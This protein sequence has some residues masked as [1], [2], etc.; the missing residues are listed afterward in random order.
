MLGSKSGRS[1]PARTWGPSALLLALPALLAV[2]LAGCGSSSSSS[3]S[4]GAAAGSSA[5]ASASTT[6]TQ[7]AA[8]TTPSASQSVKF[9]PLVPIVPGSGAGVKIGYIALDNSV[10]YI[11]TVTEGMQ[12]AAKKAGAQLFVCDAK[13]SASVAEQ[14]ARNFSVEGA[15][16]ILNFNSQAAASPQVCAAGPKVPT[17]AID[18]PQPPCQISFLGVSNVGA[19]FVDG[20]GGALAYKKKADCKYDALVIVGQSGVGQPLTE[21]QQGMIQGWTSVC[22][23]IHDMRVV[24]TQN[25][26]AQ[27][28]ET[29]TINALTAL[30]SPKKV[31]IFSLI[32]IQTDGDLAAVK[33]SGRSNDVSVLGF[34]AATSQLCA[35]MK[36]PD[37]LGD[38]LLFPEHY[39]P[40]GIPAMIKAIKHETIPTTLYIPTKFG[41]RQTIP[42]YYPQLASCASS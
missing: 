35:F 4:A 7:A 3:S 41:D 29:L 32:G 21:R 39:G 18:I 8:S 30:P 16:G 33:S 1:M 6:S 20:Q 38:T 25:G 23:A 26:T 14:C 27:E 34:G 42:H 17:I 22:G 19:G 40:I 5:T 2:A 9:A 11:R 13:S 15:Q 10:P 37:W 31:V 12:A 28:A 36:N 24:Q